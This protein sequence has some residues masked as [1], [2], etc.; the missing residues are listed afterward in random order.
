MRPP[1]WLIALKLVYF[2]FRGDKKNPWAINAPAPHGVC[3]IKTSC[4]FQRPSWCLLE[5]RGP[6]GTEERRAGN[7]TRPSWDDD[8]TARRGEHVLPFYRRPHLVSWA[9][10]QYSDSEDSTRRYTFASDSIFLSWPGGGV[11]PRTPLRWIPLVYRGLRPT[12]LNFTRKN[13]RIRSVRNFNPKIWQPTK[14]TKVRRAVFHSASNHW[15]PRKQPAGLTILLPL[16][17]RVSFNQS[18]WRR[19]CRSPNSFLQGLF[20][21]RGKFPQKARRACRT[22]RMTT[23][24]IFVRKTRTL[25]SRLHLS[26]LPLVSPC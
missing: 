26:R 8:W 13:S 25:G 3:M 11:W 21:L 6:M 5:G 2:V 23:I 20:T 12:R 18:L 7:V 22:V 19:R 9:T 15:F 24:K 16:R 17:I 10:G 1:H 4:R 14:D